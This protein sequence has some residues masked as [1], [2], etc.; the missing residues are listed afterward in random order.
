M[1]RCYVCIGSARAG[2]RVMTSRHRRTEH[3]G[4]PMTFQDWLLFS[5]A[6]AAFLVVPGRNTKR[7]IACRQAG[8]GRAATLC[9]LGC[10]TGYGIAACLVFGMAQA[11][12]NINA[13]ALSALRWP[14]MAV[15][16]V[17]ALRLWRAPLHI[18]P[19]ADNDNLADRRA[20]VIVSQAV[21]G[22]ALDARTLVFLL[23]ITTQITS[24][25]SPFSG[26]F[27]AMELAFMGLAVFAC[28]LQ[29]IYAHAFDRMIRRRSARR[30]VQP[31]GKAMLISARSVSAGYRRIAA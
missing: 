23:A 7:I 9:V 25:F 13:T 16:M 31:K 30:M 19:V 8:G 29:A 15:L 20:M 11:L 3:G 14:G 4:R 28:G 26:D 5:A 22:S 18:G 27:L 6:S 2:M 17:L 21:I 24:G 12:S 10:M 1:R